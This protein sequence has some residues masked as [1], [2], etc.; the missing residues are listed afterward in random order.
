MYGHV[1][2]GEE[3]NAP[4]PARM[5]YLVHTSSR[6]FNTDGLNNLK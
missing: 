5:E 2:H 4:N 3:L 1:Q 6:V